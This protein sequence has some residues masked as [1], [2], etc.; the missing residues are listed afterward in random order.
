MNADS[1]NFLF[2]LALTFDDVLLVPCYSEV[3]PADAST[4]TRLARDIEL[5]VPLV[6]AAM[7]SVT[8][9]AMAIAMA[10]AGA[11]GFIHKNQSIEA[12]ATAVSEAKSVKLGPGDEARPDRPTLDADGRLRVGAAVGVGSDWEDRIAALVAAGVD[13]VAIDTAHG[14]SKKVL[15]TVGS[16]RDRWPDLALVGGNVATAAAVCAL[17]EAGADAVKIGIGPG[18][19][20]TTRMV[21]GVG[22]P[23]LSAVLEAA[24]EAARLGVP[25]IADGGIRRSGD[26]VKALAAGASVVMVGSLLAGTDETP[27]QVITVNGRRLK[28]YRGMGSEGAM[29]DGSRDRYFQDKAVKLV[30]EGIEARVPYKG[31]VDEIIFQLVGGL[32][33]GMGYTGAKDLEALR[34]NRRFVR[35]TV[36]GLHESNVHDVEPDPSPV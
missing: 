2:P 21:A 28:R 30:A 6:S 11:L 25:A 8:H 13:V 5:S 17:V 24:A 29:R 23:Q 15:D 12:Q 19:I 1:N 18:S 22:V 14:H 26:V 4:R 16:V 36:A 31:A 33:A 32:R 9:C 20:C 27:G 35:V 3:L 7:D 34:H 10:R